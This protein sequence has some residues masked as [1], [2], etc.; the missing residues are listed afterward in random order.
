MNAD[1][2]G[3]GKFEM[4]FDPV[5][6]VIVKLKASMDIKMDLIPESGGDAV[7]TTINYSLERQLI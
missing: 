2:K 1:G 5:A 3:K 6:S 4:Y 7:E